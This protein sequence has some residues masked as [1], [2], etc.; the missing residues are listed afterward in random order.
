MKVFCL[1]ISQLFALFCWWGVAPAHATRQPTSIDT[2]MGIVPVDPVRVAEITE[3]L[4]EKPRGFGDPCIDRKRWSELKASGRYRKVLAEADRVSVEGL[5]VWDEALYMGF[6]TKGDS[7][8]GKDMQSGRMRAFVQLVWAECID[9]RGKYMPAIE[10]ALKELIMQKTW[11]HPRN[12]SQRNFGGLVELSTA[13]YVQNIA[14]AVYLLGDKLDSSL[15]EQAIRAL[16]QRAFKPLL[17]TIATGN[18]DHGWLTGTN[19]WNAVCLSG[20]VGAALTVIADKRERATF[21]AIGERYI[22]NFVS[23]FPRD[24]YCTEGLSYFNY[25]FGRYITLREIVLQATAGKLDLFD[26]NPIIEKNAWFLP[27]MEIINGI[28][29]AIGDC[30]QYAEPSISILSYMS[31]NLGMGLSKYEGVNLE[32]RTNDLQAD[33]MSVFPN[34]GT[35]GR[36]TEHHEAVNKLRGYFDVAGVLT[37][38][39]REAHSH[40]MGATLKGGNNAEHHNH[41]DLGSFTL[42]VGDEILVGDPGSIPYTAKTFSPQ[43][44]EYKTLG[45]YGHPVP[46]VAG[47]EQHAGADARAEV[48][49]AD[50]SAGE[51]VFLLDISSAYRVPG[52]QKLTRE[53]KYFRGGSE[54]LRVT[55]TFEFARPQAFESA[56]ITRCRWRKISANK[57]MIAGKNDSVVVTITSPGGPFVV[58]S[59]I[60]AEEHGEPYTRIGMRLVDAVESGRFI[61]EFTSDDK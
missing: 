17:K 43:R 31:R 32:G 60:I 21:I 61:M 22:H 47:T 52:L 42:V 26:E 58:K 38:R 35:S 1:F 25:G 13:S 6:F 33:L 39:P 20:V 12:F 55:D 5:P 40:S 14:E 3:M 4:S 54:R 46:L 34:S 48:M 16:Y 29:P 53:F 36:P 2:V 41:N 44:Y 49:K 11:V 37:V 50:F 15:R 7:Q 56:L 23:G 30:K 8:S 18:H 59:E 51:D 9:N 27:N 28:Y 45:S 10:K 19:N 24:G 57:L